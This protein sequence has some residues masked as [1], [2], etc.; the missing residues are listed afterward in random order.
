[1]NVREMMLAA[2]MTALIAALGFVPPLILPISP[3]PI[4]LQNMGVMLAGVLLGR[5]VGTLSAV[6]FLLLVAAGLPLLSG[7]RGGIGL[8][9]GTS[10]GYLLTFPLVAYLGGHF[11]ERGRPHFWRYFLGLLAGVLICDTAGAIWLGLA[12]QWNLQATI[13]GGFLLF[14][15]GDIFKAVAASLVALAVHRAYPQLLPH[16]R[17]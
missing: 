9:L 1:M 16:T 5:K 10:A 13:T 15:P 3:V 14:L 17:R 11:A 6:V 8:V 2:M 4:V 12:M 7:G